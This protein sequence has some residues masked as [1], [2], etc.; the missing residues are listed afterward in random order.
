MINILASEASK[1]IGFGFIMAIFFAFAV[2]GVIGYA[3]SKIMQWQ[4]KKVN[5]L[6]G[7]IVQ[8][9]VVTDSKSFLRVARKKNYIYFVKQAII[10]FSLVVLGLLLLLMANAFN[11]WNYNIFEHTKTGFGTILFVW[12][13]N[14]P[15]CYTMWFGLRILCNWPP[16]INTPH[17]EVEAIWSYFIVPLLFGGGAWYLFYVQGLIARTIKSYK[18]SKSLFQIDLDAMSL[19]NQNPISDKAIDIANKDNQN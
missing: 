1:R 15:S 13:F 18:L 19:A 7:V 6:M 12:N 9:K 8:T 11:N 16:L 3:I 5:S 14:D 17:F 2:I 4:A 10:P